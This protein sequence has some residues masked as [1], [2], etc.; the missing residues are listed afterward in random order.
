MALL[1]RGKLA[2]IATQF[3]KILHQ[4]ISSLPKFKPVVSWYS[5]IRSLCWDPF[6]SFSPSSPNA[7]FKVA[8]II[9]YRF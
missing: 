1:D 5:K 9:L 2:C 4:A 7:I 6:I 3:A 8:P